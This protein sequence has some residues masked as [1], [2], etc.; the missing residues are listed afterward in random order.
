MSLDN[1][2]EMPRSW[3]IW[4]SRIRRQRRFVEYGGNVD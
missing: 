1:G 3:S 2:H 4:Y